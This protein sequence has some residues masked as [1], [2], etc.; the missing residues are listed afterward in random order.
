M[1]ALLWFLLPVAAVFGWFSA[2]LGNRPP[3]D[4]PV[5]G[6]LKADYFRGIDYLLNEQQDKALDVFIR[7]L[8]VDAATAETHLALGNLYRRRG[9]VDRAIRIHQ[10]LIARSELEEAK[11]REALL[12]LGHDY[13]SAGL[14]DRAE[15]LFRELVDSRQYVVQALRQLI[16]IYEQE[17]DWRKAIQAA[18][19]LEQETGTSLSL[20]ISNYWCEL[21]ARARSDGDLNN[22]AEHTEMALRTDPGCVRA[23]LLRGAILLEQGEPKQAMRALKGV[24]RQDAE[25]LPETIEP[26][27]RAADAAD[28]QDGLLEFLTRIVAEHG[29]ISATLALAELTEQALGRPEAAEFMEEQ[30]RKRPSVR[31]FDRLLELQTDEGGVEQRAYAYTLKTLTTQLLADRPVYK[32]KHCGFPARSLHW[33]CPGCKHW[34]TVKPIQGVEGE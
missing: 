20:V 2:K 33:Q 9:E 4:E 8:E 27:R 24:E 7:V 5:G 29:G 30:L 25:Y 32:C 26:L 21:A 1:E 22:A 14:L 3:R 19:E 6:G 13:L 16:D 23:S 10:N 18:L 12:E 17:K 34:N 11:R 15:D 31:G 28:D